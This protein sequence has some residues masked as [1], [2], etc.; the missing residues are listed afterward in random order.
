MAI[1]GGIGVGAV[2]T[3]IAGRDYWAAHQWLDLREVRVSIHRYRFP[4]PRNRVHCHLFYGP[5]RSASAN[6]RDIVWYSMGRVPDLDHHLC[7]RGVP[8]R[9]ARLPHH[10][11]QLL[12]G[13]RPTHRY[14]YHHGQSMAHGRV[15]LSNREFC[16]YLNLYDACS[17]AAL[18]PLLTC[19]R[20]SPTPF[21]GSGRCL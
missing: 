6:R 17:S 21:N 5:I 10:L 15:G 7:L 18:F 9:P 11:Y 2:L 16:F 1:P 20:H 3:V 8:R 13:Y 19:Y 12:L 14:R 4:N